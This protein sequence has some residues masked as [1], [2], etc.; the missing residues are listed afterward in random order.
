MAY[1]KD[2]SDY[3]YFRSGFCC[4]GMKNIGWLERGHDFE[5]ATPDEGILDLL[6]EHCK[7]SVA[8]TRGIHECD[9]CAPPKTVYASRKELVRFLLGTSEIRVFSK[10]GEKYAA[11][12]L[13]Y[14][15]VHAHHYKP[16]DEFLRALEEGPGPRGQDYFELL[17]NTGLEWRKTSSPPVNQSRFKFDKIDGEE[18]HIEVQMPI[19]LDES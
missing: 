7:I 3:S 16:P 8:Q 14:H 15:Y 18:R 9:L 1:F 2:L 5:E 19:Y 17:K 10:K 6:W 13:I 12:T 4:A 11:P